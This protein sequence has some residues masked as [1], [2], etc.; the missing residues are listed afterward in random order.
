MRPKTRKQIEVVKL[1]GAMRSLTSTQLRWA[2]RETHEHFAY[3]LKSSVATCM[4]CGHEWKETIDSETMSRCP[5]CGA[6]LQVKDT[7]ERVVKQK[8]YFNIITTKADYQVIRSFQLISEMRKGY[9]AKYSA[10]AICEYWIDSKGGKTVMGLCRAM[11]S[12]FYDVFNYCSP[13]ELRH[14]NEAFQRIAD[15]WVYPRIKVTDT[16]KRNG[17]A[18]CTHHIHPVNLFKELLTNSKAETLM[19][20]GEIELLRHLTYYPAEIDKYWNSI[21]IAMRHGY[22]FEDVPMWFDYIMMLDRIGKDLHSPT[23]VAPKDLKTSHDEYVAK[24]ERQRIKEQKEADRK[25]AEADEAKF[26]ELKGR[27]VGLV[28]TDGEI[29]VHTLNSVAEY[30]DEGSRQHIC[31]GSS[32]YYLKPETLVLTAKIGNKT[33]ATI[34]ISLQ[35]CSILQ[36]RAFANGISEYQ[37]RIAKIIS[38]N[39][40]MIAERKTA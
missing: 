8:S 33:I 1:S 25:K 29:V 17:F 28:M 35:D 22:K 6:R 38:D 4:D 32:R 9:Q 14:D 3:R 16:I 30:Y 23:L 26:E 20:A 24:V 34:E 5:K 21:K 39:I 37:D 12:Y 7:K 10:L 19:K 15:E 36:C 18:G 2:F 40:K 31:C 27:Y 13:F 11:N